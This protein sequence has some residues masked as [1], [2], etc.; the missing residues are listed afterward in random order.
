M[1]PTG[2]S[3]TIFFI[4]YTSQ[5]KIYIIFLFGLFFNN[6]KIATFLTWNLYFF[7][8]F[9]CDFIKVTMLS[10]QFIYLFLMCYNCSERIIQN[11]KHCIPETIIFLV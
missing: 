5:N 3:C 4:Y 9:I 7:Y 2:N 10:P 1:N 8:I 11:F 6:I